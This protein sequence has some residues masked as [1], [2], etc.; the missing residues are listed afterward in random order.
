MSNYVDERIVEMKFN[1]KDFEQN[2]QTS[3]KTLD[4]LNKKLKLEDAGKSF[5]AIQEASSKIDLS[6]L[7][8]NVQNVSDRC[9][10]LGIV[11]DQ[12]IRKVTDAFWELSRSIV[13]AVNSLTVDQIG[14]GFEKYERKVQAVQTI[15]NATG[16]SIEEVSLQLDKLNW[17]TD[18]TSYNFADMVDNIGKFTNASVP[19]DVAVTSMI[20]I[21]D[22]AGLAG[23][24]VGDASH[25]M[26]GFSKAI[27]QGY[28]SRQNWQWVRTAHMDT[29]QFKAALIEA[30]VAQ[31]QL[32]EVSDGYFETLNGGEV[33]LANFEEFLK[34]QWM[35][36]DVMNSALSQFGGTTE[37]I[38]KEYMR[39]EGEMTTSDV[40]EQIGISTEDL[41]LKAFKA[42]QEAKTFTDAINSVK[43]AVST[44]WMVSFEKIFGNYEEARTFWTDVANELWDVFASGGESRNEMLEEVFGGA[45]KDFK[46]VL[47]E[48]GVS[49]KDFEDELNNVATGKVGSDAVEK[50]IDDYGSLA[51][52]FRFGAIEADTGR[53]ALLNLAGGMVTVSTE[54]V[55]LTERVR[56]VQEVVNDVIKGNYGVGETRRKALEDLGYSYEYI[57]GI[58]EDLYRAGKNSA[59]L[60]DIQFYVQDIETLNTVIGE[61]NEALMAFINGTS[62]ANN[63]FDALVEN[64]AKKTGQELVQESI[65][66]LLKGLNEL[67]VVGSEAMSAVFG[68]TDTGE[69]LYS[70][71]EKIHALTESFRLNDEEAEK[72]KNTFSGFLS[73][74]KILGTTVKKIFGIFSP[75]GDLFNFSGKGIL[76]YT[77]NIGEAITKFAEWY[78]SSEEVSFITNKLK[79]FV[80]GFVKVLRGLGTLIGKIGQ[81]LIPIIS[82]KYNALKNSFE[83]S[84]IR[85][86]IEKLWKG[87]KDFW[88]YLVNL[89][90]GSINIDLSWFSGLLDL[91]A[92]SAV[93]LYE[94]IRDF[95]KPF[96][97]GLKESFDK[98]KDSTSPIS[99]RFSGITDKIKEFKQNVEESGGLVRYLLDKLSLLREKI[100]KFFS[101]GKV[102]DKFQ[103]FLEKLAPIRDKLKEFISNVREDLANI[104]WG[105]VLAF[106]LG[107]SSVALIVSMSFLFTKLGQILGTGKKVLE[108]IH[109]VFSGFKSNLQVVMDSVIKLAIAFSIVVGTLTAALYILGNKIAKDDL[110]RAGS[111]LTLLIGIFGIIMIA[112]SAILSKS[113]NA[114]AAALAIVSF[115]VAIAVLAGALISLKDYKLDWQPLS[116]LIILVGL[117]AI[118]AIGLSKWGVKLEGTALYFISF[119]AAVMVLSMALEKI[120]GISTEKIDSA[121]M[122]IMELMLGLG[123][124]VTVSKLVRGSAFGILG[125]AIAIGIIMLIIKNLSDEKLKTMAKAAKDNW[126]ILAG[127]MI[128]VAALAL[129]TRLGAEKG[130]ASTGVAVALM[131]ASLL[132][133]F[134]AI[135]RF[136]S[137]PKDVAEQGGFIVGI[138]MVLMALMAALSSHGNGNG[139]KAGAGIVLMAGALFIVYFAVKQFAKLK[140]RDL[141]QGL[142]SVALIMAMFSLM[143]GLTALTKNA[144]TGP[145]IAMALTVGL[146]AAAMIILT[147]YSWDQ[148]KAGVLSMGGLLLALAILMGTLSSKKRDFDKNTLIAMGM[149]LGALIAI[150]VFMI[151]L[152]NQP[153]ESLA[154]TVGGISA[155]LLALAGACAILGKV[156]SVDKSTLGAVI[157]MIGAIIAIGY[158][159]S[160]VAEYSWDSILASAGGISACLVAIAGAIDL[161]KYSDFDWAQFFGMATGVVAAYF[162]G[163][164]LSKLATEDW[165]SYIG[166]AGAIALA[167]LAISASIAIIGRVPNKGGAW[168]ALGIVLAAIVGLAVIAYAIGWLT[169]LLD[170]QNGGGST[171]AT[172]ERAVVVFQK[173]GECIGALFGGLAGGAKSAFELASARS[174]PE[175]G[176][177]MAKFADSVSGITAIDEGVI[178]SIQHMAGALAALVGTNFLDNLA[179][180]FDVNGNGTSEITQLGEKMEAVGTSLKN[181]GESS[182]DDAT[183]KKIEN[184]IDLISQF[185]AVSK[186]IPFSGWWQKIFGS[187]DMGDFGNK[188]ALFGA[189]LQSYATSVA[190]LDVESVTASMPAVTAV[191][192]IADDIPK[193]SWFIDL[194]TGSTDWEK[195]STGLG[196]FGPALK[197]YG[198]NVKGTD[199]TAISNSITATGYI[200]QI[201]DKLPKDSWFLSLFG[202]TVNW[203]TLSEGIK[204]FGYAL[205]SYNA[206]VKT[207]DNSKIEDSIT[208]VDKINALADTVAADYGGLSYFIEVDNEWHDI[209]DGLTSFGSAL[210]AYSNKA[211][212]ISRADISATKMAVEDLWE[213]TSYL[214]PNGQLRANIGTGTN[215]WQ[216]FGQSLSSF[217][218]ALY[219]YGNGLV[220]LNYDGISKIGNDTIVDIRDTFYYLR[221]D[222]TIMSVVNSNIDWAALST[223]FANISFLLINFGRRAA[224]IDAA[225]IESVLPAT[226]AITQIADVLGASEGLAKISSGEISL[227]EF[228]T[229]LNEYGNALVEFSNLAS[230]INFENL[231]SASDLTFIGEN[232]GSSMISGIYNKETDVV[233]AMSN[234]IS[235]IRSEDVIKT[236]EFVSIGLGIATGVASGITDGNDAVV[237]AIAG[238][239]EPVTTEIETLIGI[240]TDAIEG[241]ETRITTSINSIVNSALESMKSSNYGRFSSAGT[242]LITALAVG[243]ESSSI[244]SSINY[245]TNAGVR[246]IESYYDSFYWAGYY[247]V[248]GIS[249]GIY[250]GIRNALDAVSIL[251]LRM[252]DRFLK[253]QQIQSPS[254]LYA[255][256]G[257]YITLGLAKG[258]DETSDN[259]EDAVSEM[260][261]GMIFAISP[262]LETLARLVNGELEISP[263]IHP[264]VDMTDVYASADSINKMFEEQSVSASA[265]ANSVSRN[266]SQYENAKYNTYNRENSKD[267]MSGSPTI[268]N[269]IYTQPGQSADEIA[270]AVE[271]RMVRS[272]TQRKVARVK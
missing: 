200:K 253:D 232:L 237:R 267:S 103:G 231:S 261:D 213:M 67:K 107:F 205:N 143:L 117:M 147:R 202:G 61:E 89:D 27:A 21:A 240:I 42:A 238:F 188:I 173:I 26:E 211:K 228:R 220:G 37:E 244:N 54:S 265:K 148:M 264:V 230:E 52:A 218:N 38:Y 44:G 157:L 149:M 252:N 242:Y 122:A 51:N 235:S 247:L 115:A 50:L 90:F 47:A 182:P 151:K 144:K 172:L 146:L 65:I 239:N 206:S 98:L 165:A 171:E 82:E 39:L 46:T 16:L 13:S 217:A 36:V 106:A 63:S 113:K 132:I 266:I 101:D 125:L 155:C 77:S 246:A 195:I 55:D 105:S 262:A 258:I 17:F 131:A 85:G 160:M 134:E 2:V 69:I 120:S 154:A 100:S 224:S 6:N 99:D 139:L 159:M 104:D 259:A 178:T 196:I 93:S 3:M 145:I 158:A 110:N 25:A 86:F 91:A 254:R 209:K 156:E 161:L 119:A 248:T 241:K 216:S 33:T 20:G 14:V 201:S 94:T 150:G 95:L 70:I 76:T 45:F 215:K 130:A 1:N 121:M 256:Y 62:E 73:I 4:E 53:Q 80:E 83:Q 191:T 245:L 57:Q 7:A 140:E 250:Y 268:N 269:Y 272:L 225:S 249:N 71:L 133:I 226:A 109:N 210:E 64:M 270:D 32:I 75:L 135:K 243:I 164:I 97:D 255:K 207:L 208:T 222:G 174:L 183:K 152:A 167:L 184:S 58:V 118:A 15:M 251:A 31:G 204:S 214:Y 34:D 187:Q 163:L 186:E 116:A 78:D 185:A 260:C 179:A 137:L 87:I 30:A 190:E 74:F 170:K 176:E 168:N 169:E 60:E 12:V 138:L 96:I 212:N 223:N 229:Q 180:F 43:D 8:D 108:G 189:G 236:D 257:E 197:A 18:E 59:S 72:L 41:G 199:S 49:I 92:N 193:N 123:I 84:P 177:I 124:I 29:T 5:E 102:S 203:T 166:T 227:S 127:I 11:A 79:G 271:R 10:L 112:T 162:I 219:G 153:W 234:L 136:G 35:T 114:T 9:S 28:M 263:Q 175:L 48:A 142:G 23:A 198:D 40:I 88:D 22:A 221:S 141:K 194:F 19:L 126:E 24:S 192:S 56:E 181:F 233:D 111:I 81:K 129:F 128:A 66:N 68:E